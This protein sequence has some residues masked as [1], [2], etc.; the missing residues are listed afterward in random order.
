MEERPASLALSPVGLGLPLSLGPIATCVPTLH[1]WPFNLNI[2]PSS[3]VKKVCEFYHPPCSSPL[4]PPC[5][6][7]TPQFEQFS[8]CILQKHNCRNLDAQIPT[9]P[10]VKKC[11]EYAG[12]SRDQGPLLETNV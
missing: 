11:E 6:Y 8:L 12:A 10:G 2:L 7:E 4:L 9:R 3:H 1:P 5:S